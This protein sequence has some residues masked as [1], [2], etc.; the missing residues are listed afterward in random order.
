MCNQFIEQPEQDS[1]IFHQLLL[2]KMIYK[3]YF[4]CPLMTSQVYSHFSEDSSNLGI[5]KSIKIKT[6]F[7]LCL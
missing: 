1:F 2:S 3:I 4:S 7:I 6:N 5:K